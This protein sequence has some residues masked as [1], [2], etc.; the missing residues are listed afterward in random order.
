[1]RGSVPLSMEIT[2]MLRERIASG[3][4]LPSCVTQWAVTG[5]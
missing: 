5:A 2:E 4:T 3:V 1:M